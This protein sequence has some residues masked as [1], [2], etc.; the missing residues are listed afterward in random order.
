MSAEGMTLEYEEYGA[1][2]D[3]G[4]EVL[5]VA[6]LAFMPLAFGAVE[7][8]SE[9]V[10]IALAALISVC[11]LLKASVCRGTQV[12]WTW[13]YVAVAVFVLAVILQVIPLMPGLVRLISPSTVARKSELLGDLT[14][15][16]EA[17]STMTIS[18]Y[19]HATWHDLRLVLAVVAVFFVTLNVVQRS[20]QVMHL[21]T[22]IAIIGAAF[23]LLALAQNLF[24]NDKIY[25]FV[26]TALGDGT[27]SGPF[28]NHSHYSQFMNLSV[29]AM[30]ALIIVKVREGLTNRPT[31]A[32]GIAEYLT[33]PDA[34]VVCVLFAMAMLGL[35]T[36]LM[37]LSRGGG[38]S[39]LIAGTCTALIVNFRIPFKGTG[40]IVAVLALGAFVCV[41]YIGF[42]AIYDRLATL[43]DLSELG[44]SRWQIVKDIAIAWTRFPVLGTGLGTHEVVYP[45]FDRSTIPVLASYA[46]NEYAQAAEE[47]GII[48][49][50]ALVVFAVFVWIHYVRAVRGSDR[51]LICSAAY[52]LGFGLIAIMVH[53]LSDFGQHVPANAFLSAI[54][55]ALI[56]RLSRIGDGRT[57]A[58]VGTGERARKY[59]VG[60]LVVL[61]G[62]WICALV[63]ANNARLGEGH[64]GKAL[65]AER[66]LM[67]RD[68]QGS[69]EEYSYLLSHAMKAADRQPGNVKYQHWLNIYRWH[70]ISRT[71][72]PN[73]GQIVLPAEAM[74]FAHQIVERLNHVR[75]LCPTFGAT[76]CVLG[77]LERS[78]LGLN[79]E[80]A[81]H[82]RTGATLGPC[83]P[84]ARLAA[85][86]LEAEEGRTDLAFEHLEKAIELDERLFPDVAAVLVDQLDRL[87]VIL[88]FAGD[89]V[90]RL[91]AA[92]TLL[93][94]LADAQDSVDG[95][96][97]EAVA[98]LEQRCREDAVAPL[99]LVALAQAFEW[100]GHTSQAI[101]YYSKA[102]ESDY[103]KVDWHFNLAKLYEKIGSLAEAIGEAK[104]CLHFRPEHASAKQLIERLS[105]D[106]RLAEQP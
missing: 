88:Q 14:N 32:E 75:S 52:G 44:S 3:R 101:E 86:Q 51:V 106:S 47:T 19:P 99:T 31:T 104:V 20:D 64:W 24:G 7:A 25:W 38:L 35:A 39:M 62:L 83:D 23:A 60:G 27:R 71:T 53:S 65:A 70:T 30:L 73:T 6:L 89:D 12:A 2:F 85:G 41:L 74:E 84:T 105:V 28:V 95:V 87:D 59:W 34:K 69:D 72:D 21:L 92:L 68:W 17:L 40:W 103:S 10:V 56:I 50:L 63:D 49:L 55:C 48:G 4:I 45:E 78:L 8:W 67:E 81:R 43:A 98:R 96:H 46:E 97:R 1:R 82:I 26:P 54:F 5:L 80:G 94:S 22:A 18:F 16:S 37:S 9:E 100:E 13:S 57:D 91:C 90:E 58:V 36:M 93:E 102:L 66:N 11:F 29:G 33:S 79:E 61:S 76:W 42:D 15:A 77:Q